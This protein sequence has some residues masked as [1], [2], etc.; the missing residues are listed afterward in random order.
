MSNSIFRTAGLAAALLLVAISVV[1]GQPKRLTASDLKTLAKS[2]GG[3]FSSEE[4]A[5]ADAAF[6]H[7]KL[8]MKPIWR[9]RKDGF[10]FYVEQAAAETESKPYRQRVYRLFRQDDSTIVSKVFEIDEPAKLVGAWAD[11]TKLATLDKDKL[12]DRQGCSILLHKQSDG[13]FAGSTPGKECLSS[14]RGASYATSEVTI[15]ADKIITWDRGW[16]KDGKQVW[17][18]VKGGY[19]FK[20]IRSL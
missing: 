2:M 14:L 12:I 1:T 4:Q 19:T 8:R 17:G 6:F 10:W 20:K 5:K 13:T 15:F 16:D 9:D 18:A 7:I 11:E 3:D